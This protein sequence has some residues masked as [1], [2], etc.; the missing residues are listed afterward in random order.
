MIG[1]RRRSNCWVTA[2]ECGQTAVASA[3]QTATARLGARAQELSGGRSVAAAAAAAA[4]VAVGHH[5]RTPVGPAAF[6]GE[7]PSGSPTAGQVGARFRR[8][9]STDDALAHQQSHLGN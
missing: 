9:G 1:I 3:G 6:Q 2:A 5:H 8:Y 7:R 4:A